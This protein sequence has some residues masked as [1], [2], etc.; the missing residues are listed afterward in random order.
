[1]STKPLLAH[2]ESLF[3]EHVSS[4]AFG[5]KTKR[6]YDFLTSRVIG[7]DRAAERLARSF[8]IYHAGLKDQVKPINAVIFAG[9]T[10]VGKTLMA[11]ELARA[12]IADQ[13]DAPLTF[14]DCTTF[15]EHHQLAEL[16]GSP[17]GYVGFDGTPKLA[18]MKIDDFHFWMK[19]REHVRA[20][21]NGV[22]PDL[23]AKKM[24]RLL[25]EFY[26]RN[27]PY[28]SVVLFDEIEKAHRTVHNALLRI[29]DGG[30][31]SLANGDITDFSSS[32]I[33]L[34]CNI[35]GQRSNELLSG[36][37]KTIGLRPP[38]RSEKD[39]ADEIDA[40]I[41]TETSKLIYKFFPAEFVGRI[42]TNI[43]VFRSL[44]REQSARVLELM[45]KKEQDKLTGVAANNVPVQLRFSD[46][47]KEFLLDEG[48]S[49]EY[50]LRELQ[51]IVNKHVALPLANAI[52]GG[53]VEP[54]DELMFRVDEF[55]KPGLYRKHRPVLL[56]PGSK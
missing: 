56:S 24:E 4:D 47:Y 7:Q 15:T 46:G 14:I 3:T 22:D 54:G 21:L 9:P 52:E 8:A 34:T 5:P 13:A 28:L 38:T 43:I 37:D 33:M 36:N 32:V 12:L 26:Q 20:N 31:L 19:W 55:N 42:R 45:L 48:V 41:Y 10:G 44:D 17:P 35:G 27:K 49:R 50:G 39:N 6:I 53:E 16:I 2:D 18:Q 25:A 11:Q 40:A 1:M 23:D 51:Q 30:R 29:I